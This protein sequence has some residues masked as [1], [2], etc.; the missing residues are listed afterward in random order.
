MPLD[1]G[2]DELTQRSH[3]AAGFGANV[4]EGPADQGGGHALALVGVGDLGVRE[5]DE[6]DVAGI[7]EIV[8]EGLLRETGERLAQ[9]D[10]V[11]VACLVVDDHDV[12]HGIGH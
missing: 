5:G 8:V 2:L 4:V 7:V 1:E 10:L 6:S 12:C 3:P 11:A 9:P